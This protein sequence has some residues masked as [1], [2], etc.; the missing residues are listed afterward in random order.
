MENEKTSRVQK[1][2]MKTFEGSNKAKKIM[3]Q[4][5]T[6]ELSNAKK[7]DKKSKSKEDGAGKTN[8]LFFNIFFISLVLKIKKKKTYFDNHLVAYKPVS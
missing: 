2:E 5:G 8:L 3:M 4:R 7:D 1:R 6:L